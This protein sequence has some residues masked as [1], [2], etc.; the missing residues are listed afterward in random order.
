MDERLL[1][2]I[3]LYE[4]ASLET[5]DVIATVSAN[6]MGGGLDVDLTMIIYLIIFG[7][8]YVILKAW[9]FDP[10]LK[11][12]DKRE[13]STEGTRNEA[14]AL[15]EKANAAIQSYEEQLSI[16]KNAAAQQRKELKD[17]ATAQRVSK[18][19]EALAERQARLR[20]HRGKLQGQIASAREELRTEAKVLSKL[21]TERLVPS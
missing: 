15:K 17:E 8:S 13:E 1:N 16:A 5:Y 10:Y 2:C 19:E 9:I 20:E 7:A 11:I 14:A 18:E 12:K 21:I 4:S 6:T 3:E